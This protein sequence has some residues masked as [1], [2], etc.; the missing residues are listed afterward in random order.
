MLFRCP[1]HQ[2]PPRPPHAPPE[3]VVTDQGSGIQKRISAAHAV[4]EAPLHTPRLD[5]DV[6]D[7]DGG[8][9]RDV[10]EIGH[11]SITV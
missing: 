2:P 11:G 9:G 7:G 4:Y 8:R 10:S 1:L 6:V 3:I 5:V